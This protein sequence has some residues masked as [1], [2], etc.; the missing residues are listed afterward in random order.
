MTG[1]IFRVTTQSRCYVPAIPYDDNC[2]ESS[3]GT[4]FLV[5]IDGSV[6]VC[7]AHH[8]ISNAVLI[9]GTC[10]AISE[11]VM[12][13]CVGYNPHLDLA[14]LATDN[15][16]V[17]RLP[18]FALGTSSS[19]KPR[20]R[21]TAVGF[22]DAS[23]RTHTTSGTITGRIDWPHNR[24]QTD[25][26]INSG[27]SGGPILNGRGQ[28]VGLTTT[29]MD[30]MQNTN[31]FLMSDELQIAVRRIL[32]HRRA[33]AH[34]VGIDHGFFLPARVS[35]V[36]RAACLGEEGGAL[37]TSVRAGSALC[38][39]DVIRE[40]MDAS[41][42]M[43]ALDVFMKCLV[44]NTWEHDTID[45]RSILDTVTSTQP[46]RFTWNL[47][48]RRDGSLMRVAVVCGPDTRPTREMFPDCECMTYLAVGGL[49]L[50]MLHVNLCT[51]DVRITPDVYETSCP[52]VTHV[53]AGCPYVVHG[54]TR[55]TALRVHSVIVTGGHVIHT[56]TLDD[57]ATALPKGIHVFVFHTGERVGASPE[58][59]QNFLKTNKNPR[60]ADG[61]H[62]AGRGVLYKNDAKPEMFL[63]HLLL[64]Q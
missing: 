22:A 28:V 29:G 60:T 19:M 24:C 53:V 38:E 52:V 37:V 40:A 46:D 33:S 49:I 54:I 63:Q 58:A 4:A 43:V 44:P 7:T 51:P 11:V 5:S 57:I 3:V 17:L 36:D 42:N 64:V 26:T 6:H 30:H 13:R 50:Q 55:V 35:A 32:E 47:V 20:D 31:F 9:S 1:T 59:L 48:V 16:G 8:V 14:V 10:S 61:M 25:T 39:G 23:L 34:K 27:N 21:V 2:D 12:F 45:F 15:P 56:N 18:A 62:E 41:G